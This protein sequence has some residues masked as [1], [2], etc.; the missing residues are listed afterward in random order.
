MSVSEQIFYAFAE[1][2]YITSVWFAK[3]MAGLQDAAARLHKEVR[4][5]SSVHDLPSDHTPAAVALISDTVDW[6]RYMIDE[7]NARGIRVILQGEAPTDYSND[8]SGPVLDR[9]S[10]VEHMV[11]YFV[12]A[13]RRRLASVGNDPRDGNDN[14]RM[15]VFLES[16]RNMGISASERDVFLVDADLDA[17]I[18]RFL[19]QIDRYDGAICV[20]DYVAVQL[21]VAAR[22]RGIAVPERL[23]VAGSGNMIMGN[24]T[25]P[26]L[27]T[28]TL[29][30]YEMGYQT[31]QL[32]HYLQ[33]N[34]GIS[35]IHVS[36]PC[37]LI[38][39]GS[40]A[41][42]PAPSHLSVHAEGSHPVNDLSEAADLRLRRLENCLLHCDR[43]DFGIIHGVLEG[44]SGERIADTL[45][46]S[47]GTVQYRLKKLYQ[48]AGVD[49]RRAFEALLA[50]YITN[51]EFLD[52]LLSG[53]P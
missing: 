7:L 28:S 48:R 3:S 19:E 25:T 51:H 35:A 11:Q 15:R 8:I 6:T 1:P 10:L 20:N 23:F 22:Q 47:Q 38:C 12:S 18:D 32:G 46:I 14:T 41:F 4:L 40:T 17:C 34:P 37:E 5:L 2:N 49:S 31:V 44:L 16:L 9:Q 52:G 30:Y 42:L 33:K 43:L 36:I 53:D 26:T 29:N 13:G 45:F 39:R 21:L 24:C 27:T 50:P